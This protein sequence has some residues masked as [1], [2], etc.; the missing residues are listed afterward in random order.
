MQD[1]HLVY[2]QLPCISTLQCP[3]VLHKKAVLEGLGD[4]ALVK[5]V[6]LL[7]YHRKKGKGTKII[8]CK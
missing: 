1:T 4:H 2:M 6:V 8:K 7:P 3:I 5:Q